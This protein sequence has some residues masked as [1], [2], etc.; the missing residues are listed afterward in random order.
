M[1]A[2]VS[3]VRENMSVDF[4]ATQSQTTIPLTYMTFEGRNRGQGQDGIWAFQVCPDPE[5]LGTNALGICI[6]IETLWR[7]V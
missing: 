6:A 4:D 3:K 7:E 5:S 1:K 2:F